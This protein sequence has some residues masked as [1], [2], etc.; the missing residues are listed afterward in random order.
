M[1]EHEARRRAFYDHEAEE[2]WP[3][4]R[5]RRPVADWGVGEDSFERL[6]SRRS[7]RVEGPHARPRAH[8]ERLRPVDRGAPADGD[9]PGDGRRRPDHAAPGRD[10]TP[11]DHE[12][13]ATHRRPTDQA[14]PT[15]RSRVHG[16]GGAAADRNGS[17]G[18]AT[19]RLRS[20]PVSPDLPTL[21]LEPGEDGSRVRAATDGRRTI[22]I[23]GRPDPPPRPTRRRPPRTAAERVGASPDRI[24]AYAVALGL[25]LILIAIL[26][27]GH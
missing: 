6:P 14:A 18:A 12:A 26:S 24:V 25:L 5:R 9:V 27:A 2:A 19:G 16:S 8:E 7:A 22:V 4:G 23:G 11:A 15:E 13:P 20:E 1:P 17:A 3:A 10:G 21:V